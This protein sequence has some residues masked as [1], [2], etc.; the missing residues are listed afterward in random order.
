MRDTFKA[1][2]AKYAVTIAAFTCTVAAVGMGFSAFIA[3]MC[4]LAGDGPALLDIGLRMAA[5]TVAL[6]VIIAAC[7]AWLEAKG[8]WK[9]ERKEDAGDGER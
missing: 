9:K 1:L 8:Y 2:L 7:M 5:G 6:S 3:I 4:A